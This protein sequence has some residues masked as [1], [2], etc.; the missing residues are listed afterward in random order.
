M[1]TLTETAYRIRTA[2]AARGIEAAGPI[3]REW[4]RGADHGAGRGVEAEVLRLALVLGLVD[5]FLNQARHVLLHRAH[6]WHEAPV[7]TADQDPHTQA[8]FGQAYAVRAAIGALLDE[9]LAAVESDAPDAH[10]TVAVAR[11]Y[12]D[13]RAAELAN[14][15]IGVLGASSA[16]R[17][18]GLDRPWRELRAFG[19][20]HPPALSL[21]VPDPS[22]VRFPTHEGTPS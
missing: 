3:G 9:A 5:G 13:R 19:Q 6:P 8:G 20:A 11:A 22:T 4:S 2:A 16:T 7:E 1:T 12:A 18:L 10:D 21:A 15:V 14:A 17:S